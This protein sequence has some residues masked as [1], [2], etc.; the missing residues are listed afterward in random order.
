V[1]AALSAIAYDLEP[2]P[3]NK[4]IELIMSTQQIPMADEMSA[5]ARRA[6]TR[7]VPSFPGTIA[8]KV[9]AHLAAYIRERAI[10]RAEKELMDLDDRM[11]RD[12]GLA[13]S[14]IPST[15]RAAEREF[16]ISAQP[17]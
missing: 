14:E 13:R 12:I 2:S 15:V 10:R 11:L 16:L 3:T 1:T 7:A 4:A 8:Q 9:R 5:A 17:K 6:D